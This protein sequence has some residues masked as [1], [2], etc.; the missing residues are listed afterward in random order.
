VTRT[1]TMD[2]YGNFTV[3]DDPN[4]AIAVALLVATSPQTLPQAES[5]LSPDGDGLSLQGIGA[6]TRVTSRESLPEPFDT[7]PDFDPDSQELWRLFRE[8]DYNYRSPGWWVVTGDELRSVVSQAIALRKAR[9]DNH[10]R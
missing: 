10:A 6:I 3:S 2:P 1:V 9:D 5:A 4:G 7:N 8:P